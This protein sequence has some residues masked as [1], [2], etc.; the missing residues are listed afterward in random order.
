MSCR[1]IA[2]CC[3]HRTSS[4]GEEAGTATVLGRVGFTV[5]RA[6]GKAVYRNRIKR[7]MRE[8]VR[9]QLNQL[10]PNWAIVIN[11]RRSVLDAPFEDLC[12][13]TGR[14]FSRCADRS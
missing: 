9:T 10:H 6:V 8:A 4:A 11:P 5:P 13:E 1:H 2:A 14:M 12:R 7:R 3:L